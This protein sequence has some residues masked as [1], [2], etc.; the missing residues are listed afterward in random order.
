MAA[1][2]KQRLLS[3]KTASRILPVLAISERAG[4]QPRPTTHRSLV[5]RRSALVYRFLRRSWPLRSWNE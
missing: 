5:P 1:G 3:R 2:H 4:E